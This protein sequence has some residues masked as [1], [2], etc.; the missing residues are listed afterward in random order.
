MFWQE[1]AASSPIRL[2]PGKKSPITADVKLNEK[3]RIHREENGWYFVQ[4][5]NGYTGYIEKDRIKLQD[6][7]TE[8]WELPEK[9]YVPWNPLGGKI[10]LTWEAVYSRNP[11]VSQIPAMPG[12]NV[13]SPTWFELSDDQ[14]NIKNK[15]DLNYTK[16]AH[17]R[18]YQ[19]WALFSNGFLPDQ[20]HE[21]LKDP[22]KRMK[23][24][25]QLISYAQ[26]YQLDGINIDFENVYLKDKQRLVQFVRELTPYLH[27]QDLVVSIDVTI[28]SRSENWSMF[29]DRAALAEVVDYVMVMTY[30]EHWGSSPVAGSVASL[31]WVEEGLKGV[32]EEV[33]NE[34]LLLGVPM[35]TRLWKEEKKDG[36]TVV[37][38]DAYTMEG[39]ENWLREHEVELTY[40]EASG[41]MYGEYVDEQ[42]GA[43][44]KV[45]V[46]DEV[47]MEKRIA[48][49]DKYDLAG[50]ASWSRYFAK[51][52][53]WETIEQELKERPRESE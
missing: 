9:P 14:G 10:N 53:I 43:T 48:L 44:Y 47:S 22:E 26:M 38:Q 33:P 30:D 36:K 1:E 7:Q 3:V 4:K 50:V 28:K 13:V 11:D 41:Q 29:Y 24:I 34:K 16:W 19:V 2:E 27:E 21:V 52:E 40:D 51:P 46:E 23:M 32:L 6:I 45:W 17:D 12:V 5:E 25:R 42:S 37:S 15:A 49:V 39:I 20:T 8:K 35:Y 31:P 18:G